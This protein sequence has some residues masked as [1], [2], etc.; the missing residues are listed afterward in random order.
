M[1]ITLMEAIKERERERESGTMRRGW[2]FEGKKTF[3][4]DRNDMQVNTN[5]MSSVHR[6]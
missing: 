3:R 6:A 4:M 1:I 2:R 5:A